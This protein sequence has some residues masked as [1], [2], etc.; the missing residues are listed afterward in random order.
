MIRDATTHTPLL[1]QWDEIATNTE[2][3]GDGSWRHAVF[4]VQLPAIAANGKYTIEFVK[5][6]GTYSAT[7]KQTLAGLCAAHDLNIL[8]NHV[9]NQDNSTRDSG[10]MSFRIC[11]NINNVGRDAPQRVATGPVRDSWVIRGA[12]VY[13]TSGHKDPLIYVRYY[14][15]VYTNPSDQTSVGRVRHIANIAN[16]WMNVAAGTAGNSGAPGPAG[17]TND[18]QVVIYSPVVKDGSTVLR[19]YDA[20]Y[21]MTVPNPAN[22]TNTVNQPANTSPGIGSSN[23][24]IANPGNVA[25]I[26]SGTLVTDTTNP[27]AIPA[28]CYIAD[29]YYQTNFYTLSCSTVAGTR[30][31]GVQSGDNLR[32]TTYWAQ[33][34]NPTGTPGH[35]DLKNGYF[36]NIK[37]L[38]NHFPISMC[39][40]YHTSGT[41]PTGL[42]NN[43]IYYVNP[44]I[45]NERLVAGDRFQLESTADYSMPPVDVTTLGSGQ[46]ELQYRI[47]HYKFATWF[48]ADFDGKSLWTG[49]PSSEPFEMALDQGSFTGER[50]YWEETG[51]VPPITLSSASFWASHFSFQDH[52][53]WRSTGQYSPLGISLAAG[54]ST[55]GEHSYIG[56][57]AEWTARWWLSQDP[58]Q[59]RNTRMF[60]LDGDAYPATSILNEVTGRIPTVNNGPP[61]GSGPGGG[62]PYIGM[63][64]LY[65]HLSVPGAAN[66]QNVTQPLAQGSCTLPSGPYSCSYGGYHNDHVSAYSVL[67][68]VLFGDRHWLDTT[69]MQGNRQTTIRYDEPSGPSRENRPSRSFLFPAGSGTPPAGQRYYGSLILGEIDLQGPRAQG[70]IARNL[71]YAAALGADGDVERQYFFDMVKENDNFWDAMKQHKDC[72]SPGSWSHNPLAHTN[73]QENQAF[74]NSYTIFGK[75]PL[76]TMLHDPMVYDQ[77]TTSYLSTEQSFFGTSGWPNST[78]PIYGGSFYYFQWGQLSQSA[79]GKCRGP[80]VGTPADFGTVEMNILYDTSNGRVLDFKDFIGDAVGHAFVM[81][82]GDKVKNSNISYINGIEDPS[83]GGPGQPARLG[84]PAE[85]PYDSWACVV[86]V[87]NTNS[88]F[89]VALPG[90]PNNDCTTPGSLITSFSGIDPTYCAPPPLPYGTSLGTL[91]ASMNAATT[92]WCVGGGALMMRMQSTSYPRVNPGYIFWSY[93]GAAAL[94]AAGVSG[95]Q[96]YYNQALTTGVTRADVNSSNAA[97]DWDPTVVV[98]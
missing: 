1:Y 32:F 42:T 87:N 89:Q 9:A 44:M 2:N 52:D 40:N 36:Q 16:S 76:W 96:P 75:Y 34:N 39:Y 88:T 19:D 91:P 5:A 48:T 68:F 56:I 73:L 11:D 74:M 57:V 69:R 45:F 67:N 53:D 71:A 13:A 72:G 70:W 79:W 64:D 85:I 22:P 66:F 30:G 98:R 63:G 86:N 8:F 95:V 6:S 43:T 47:C 49:S 81:T 7:G 29:P 51:V 83:T 62:T 31:N 82:A 21:S 93:N 4:S 41:P 17:F 38:T 37:G 3:D 27:G 94:L 58:A 84:G 80:Y 50:L 25:G 28:G 24:M 10:T 97:F 92:W 61:V 46:Q 59:I 78:P 65:P 12:P 54:G 23:L 35:T 18:P 33:L 90:A 14:I 77:F 55:G 20:M 15:D 26:W 60:A